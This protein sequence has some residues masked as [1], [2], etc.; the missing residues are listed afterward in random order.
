M[1][2]MIRQSCRAS[3]GGS[4]AL[5]ILMTRPSVL[6][7][8]PFVL[9]VQRA[10]QHD[11]GVPGRLAQ[12]EVDRDVEL[13]LLEHPRDEVAVRQRDHR[14]EA[15]REQPADLAAIDLAEDLVGS[16]RPACGSSSGSMP[17]T[18]AM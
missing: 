17:Q 16:R 15:D 14:V 2:W 9:L 3:P 7:D 10:G 5:L 4:T 11:V 6:R 1:S 18:S 8:D 13:E 12:E